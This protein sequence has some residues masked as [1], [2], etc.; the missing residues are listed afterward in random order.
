MP[1]IPLSWLGQHVDL[2][3]APDAQAL[4]AA[5]VKVG[6]EEEAI[7]PPAVTGPLVVGRVL[8]LVKETHKN[9]K[10]VNYCRVDVGEHNDA[11]GTGKEPSEVPSRGIV[12]GAHNFVEGD[13][14][15]VSLPGTVLPGPFPIAARKTYGHTSDG[16]ICSGRE[17]GLSDEHDGII[18]LTEVFPGRE[19]TPG[20]DAISL[21]GLGEEVLEVNVTPDRGYC[22][23][24]RGLAREYAHSTGAAFTDP[25]LAPV[26]AQ[27]VLVGGDDVAAGAA[28]AGAEAVDGLFG[29]Q[30][31]D[32]APIHGKP[33]CDVFTTRIVRGIDPSAPT[34]AWMADRLRLAG[35]RPISLAVDV[36]NYVM[37]DLGQPL[38]AYDLGK[39][40]A[41]LVVRRAEA[42]ERFT[43]LDGVER[44]LDAQ[45][46]LITDSPNGALGSRIQGL[47]GVMGGAASEVSATTTDVLVEAAHF[48][49]VSVARTARRHKLPSEAAKRFE[50]GVDPLL[51]AVASQAVV[52]LLV[53]YGGGTAEGAYLQVGEPSLPSAV[54]FPLAEVER[55]TGLQLGEERIVELL[56][57]IGATVTGQGGV[58]SVTPPSWR[59]DLS[60]PAHFVEEVARLEGYDA[61]A[62][63]VP[64]APAGAGLSVEQRIRRE[65]GLL[66]A[67][68]GL[69]EVMTD[70]FV[71]G[72]DAALGLAE[73]DERRLRLRLAN[74]LADDAPFLRSSLLETL[75]GAVR[76]NV[77]RGMQD[78]ALFELGL[79]PVAATAKGNAPVAGGARPDEQTLAGLLAATP[80][81][82]LKLAAVFTGLAVQAGPLSAARAYDWADAVQ[83]AREVARV[84]GA[85]LEVRGV[86]MAPW[87]PGRCAELSVDGAVVGHAGE[88]HPRVVEGFGLP[89]RACALELDLSL[90]LD[91]RP[92]EVVKTVP[93]ST[94]P[95]A[96][97]DFAFVVPADM[98]V[99]RVL[100]CVRAA[101]GELAEDVRLFDVYTGASVGDGN[102]S[103]A[104][105]VRLRAANKTLTNEELAEARAGIIAAAEQRLGARLR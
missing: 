22:F 70:P 66:L 12:C 73:G 84:A 3:A 91:K 71:A 80:R 76:R 51:P 92:R 101:A 98:P 21:L 50:R 90:L 89:D 99:A 93:V 86:E 14:V 1:L 40:A 104:V 27:R 35:M 5:L 63:V 102:K 65:I 9:G 88:L 32:E 41:P 38:H 20:Q 58:R 105:A 97:E 48:D 42:G 29:V 18:V 82:P 100:E 45:D 62:S 85:Q 26:R 30:L 15:V 16:M 31:A 83:T 2:S 47:A 19:F 28:A 6:I 57:E 44:T 10:T 69:T 61:I 36:T 34:P 46:L 54:D 25:G 75:L 60:G 11:P 68:A 95:V 53:E 37:L 55:L 72:D 56:E 78:L 67:G 96:K 94:F 52:D 77:A 49:P 79:V 81:Q 24:M 74:P 103:V 17:L 33:G 4:A 43:T 23:S 59:S 64:A 87:H 13:F 7:V 39:L 8:T